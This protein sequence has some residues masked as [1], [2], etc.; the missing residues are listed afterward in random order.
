[1]ALRYEI[2]ETLVP[3]ASDQQPG[4]NCPLVEV[5]TESEFKALGDKVEQA[6][7]DDLSLLAEAESCY[8]DVY[9]EYIVGSMAVPNK[10]DLMGD[11]N[12]FSY[13]W[14]PN[15]L[16]FIDEGSL[17]QD[18]MEH[19]ANSKLDVKMTTASCLYLFMRQLLLGDPTWLGD[20]EDKMED[21]EDAL[22]DNQRNISND[23]LASFRRITVRLSAYYQQLATVALELSENDN[24]LM[25][26]EEAS[27]FEQIIN[28][29]DRLESRAE[30]I[31]E[32]SLTLRELHQSQ[33]DIAQ[34]NTMQL[35]TI[36]TVLIAPLTLI[37]GW[38][39]MNFSYIPG[40][41]NPAGFFVIS[42]IGIAITVC[43]IV[44]FRRKKWL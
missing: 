43:L 5:L 34:N 25:T 23:D 42:A 9:P 30:T 20:L 2:N 19:V 36:V 18:T 24:R 15:R 13:Y 16:V 33:I 1:M 7:R 12:L 29:A 39:G 41:D 26:S 38:F 4:P 17:A 22:L 14:E 6:I 8:V 35:L 31:R 11:R 40:T 21:A 32:Y 27:C 3:L 37:G 44:W 28:T 10:E